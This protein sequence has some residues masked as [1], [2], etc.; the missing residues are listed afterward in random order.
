MS[1]AHWHALCP[2]DRGVSIFPPPIDRPLITNKRASQERTLEARSLS[3]F[4]S[5]AVR[6]SLCA[7]SVRPI[8]SFV[9]LFRSAVI[10]PLHPSTLG[11]AKRAPLTHHY[12]EGQPRSL[13]RGCISRAPQRDAF[14]SVAWDHWNG[15]GD[16]MPLQSQVKLCR[17]TTT[18]T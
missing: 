12:I 17:D 2:S 3:S 11:A 5:P 6:P 10:P 14:L 13:G 18:A 4:L 1:S 9:P 7:L 15:N 16:G 8:S